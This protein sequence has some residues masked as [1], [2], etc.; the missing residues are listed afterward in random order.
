MFKKFLIVIMFSFLSFGKKDYKEVPEWA[1][2]FS[3]QEYTYFINLVETFFKQNG[4]EFT[5]TDGYVNVSANDFGLNTLGLT[6]LAQ[7]CYQANRS[8][9]KGIISNHFNRM[10]EISEFESEF[11]KKVDEFENVK[12]YIG[13]RIYP[14]GYVQNVG[15]ENTIYRNVTDEL[16]ELL[17]F[18]L[19][20]AVINVKQEVSKKWEINN[21]ELFS[22]GE[23]NIKNNYNIDVTEQ[24]MTDFDIWFIQSD[25]VFASN[26]LLHND[27]LSKYLGKKGAIIGAPHRHAVIIY[28]INELEEVIKAVNTLPFVISGMYNEG[29]GSISEKMFWYIDQSFIDLPYKLTEDK[30]Q[31][32]PPEV[33]VN[34]LNEFKK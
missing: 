31:F 20:H 28:P 6:N 13:V 5:L 12:K 27:E 23:K 2:F 32:F 18:D 11:Y 16:V 15:P 30:L 4:F 10:I 7:T 33:F 34:M 21:E 14:I 9:W 25:H 26:I 17:I 19:P 29:P 8:R 22:I 1:N 3:Q 24:S